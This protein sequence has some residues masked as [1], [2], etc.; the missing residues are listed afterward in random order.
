MFGASSRYVQSKNTLKGGSR[1]LENS[2]AE[3]DLATDLGALADLVPLL[4]L[5][6]LEEGVQGDLG[7]ANVIVAD[8]VIVK[9]LDLEVVAGLGIKDE[10]LA[11]LDIAGLVLVSGSLVLLT[12]QQGVAN[13]KNDI[14]VVLAENAVLALEVPGTENIDLDAVRHVVC[15]CGFVWVCVGFCRKNV[16]R[17]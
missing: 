5:V 9:D 16:G 11:E 13:A 4:D 10:T 7:L 2:Q 12:A 17:M 14:G 6:R 8:H 1:L 15:V 3:L